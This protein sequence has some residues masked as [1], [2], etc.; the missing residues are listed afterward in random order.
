MHTPSPTNSS[1][2]YLTGRPACTPRPVVILPVRSS[3]RPSSSGLLDHGPA[4]FESADGGS[5]P[6]TAPGLD[7]PATDDGRTAPVET[8]GCYAPWDTVLT[9]T[10][11][12]V[13]L[14]ASLVMPPRSGDVCVSRSSGTGVDSAPMVVDLRFIIDAE[15]E[16][17]AELLARIEGM[18]R[19]RHA[20]TTFRLQVLDERTAPLAH[21]DEDSAPKSKATSVVKMWVE[22]QGGVPT[23]LFAFDGRE[24]EIYR[25][26]LTIPSEYPSMV[27]EITAHAITTMLCAM[28]SG[29]G[30]QHLLWQIKDAAADDDVETR[31]RDIATQLQAQMADASSVGD[32]LESLE[33]QDVRNL[34]SSSST[35]TSSSSTDSLATTAARAPDLPTPQRHRRL[36]ITAGYGL[37]AWTGSPPVAHAFVLAS[38]V[39]VFVG[40]ELGFE[41]QWLPATELD[42]DGA[43]VDLV[44]LPMSLEIGWHS[45]PRKRWLVGGRLGATSEYARVE[46]TRVGTLQRISPERSL[47]WGIRAVVD[48]GLELQ[49]WW[50]VGLYGGAQWI[51]GP[52]WMLVGGGRP[53]P[54]AAGD[55]WRWHAGVAMK[56]GFFA[57]TRGPR[58]RAD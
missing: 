13:A 23:D 11:P 3:Q 18:L 58:D 52:P 6:Q 40:L 37:H 19:A 15:D 25:R 45:T 33:A 46:Q 7:W 54:V 35:N 34:D 22:V 5:H 49:P 31:A 48:V 12:L 1:R 16:F 30:K 57:Y 26:P 47:R 14:V 44:R 51:E 21:D 41:V 28:K 43:R 8:Q 56:F 9:P 2:C 53:Q 38:L 55:N 17:Q 10:I 20:H 4:P 42:V 32:N 39:E 29:Q 24:G 50:T 36:W 27:V